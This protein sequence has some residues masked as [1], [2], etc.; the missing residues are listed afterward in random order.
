MHVFTVPASAPFLRTVIA[1]LIDGEL[2]RGFEARSNPERLAE[3]T[4]Y[5]PT[6]R[7]MRLARDVFLDVL[8]TDAAILPRL[9]AL[10]DIDEDELIFAQ[11]ASNAPATA[12][13]LPPAV[14]AFE[15]RLTLAQLVAAWAARLKPVAPHTTPLVVSGPASALAL[16]DELARLMDDMQTRGVSWEALD[17]LVP[18]TY[19]TYWQLTLDFLKIARQAWPAYLSEI[20]RIEPFAR[21]DRLI[22][23]EAER[24]KTQHRGPVVAA[25]STGSMPSTATFLTAIARLPNGAVVLPGLDTDLDEASWQSIGGIADATGGYSAHPAQG[26]P[27]YALHMLL[28]QFGI[29]RSQ[30]RALASP[31]EHGRELLLSEVMRPADSTAQWQARLAA[32]EVASRIDRALDR[33]AVIEAANPEM[34][35]LAIAIAMR[36]ADHDG[37]TTALVTPDRALARR[38]L[39]ALERWKL[40]CN[41]SGGDPLT[42]TPAGLFARLIA[43]AIA[44]QLAPADLLALLKHPLL[45]LGRTSDALKACVDDLELLLLRGTRPLAGIAGLR[46]SLDLVCGEIAKLRRGEPSLL[47]RSELR[48]QVSDAR[49]D[50]VR[51]LIDDLAGALAPMASLDH[52]KSHDIAV[53]AHAHRETAAL[54][55]RDAQDVARVF[56]GPDGA[57]LLAAFDEASATGAHGRLSAR[58]DEYP[59]VLQTA[60]SS[61]IVRR[62]ELPFARLHIYGQL[63]ARLTQCDRVI[64]GGLTETV[65]P[66]DP[67]NDPWLSRPMRYQINLDLP[68]RRIGLSAHDFVQL[69]G[70]PEVILTHAA[71]VGGAPAVASRFLHR[72]EAVA[73]ATRWAA[74]RARGDVYLRHAEDLDRP[75]TPPKPI[76]QPA[77]KPPRDARP[78]ALSVTEIEDWLRDP[79]TIY[80]RHILKLSPLDPVDMPLS[81]ADRGSAI[82]NAL[83]EFTQAF[84]DA[85]PDDA[86]RLLREIGERHFAPLME[87]PEA[88]A[89]WWPRYLRIAAWFADWETTR[90]DNLATIAAESYGSIVL[91]ADGRSF[92]LTARADRIETLRDGRFAI[93]DYKTGAPPTGKQVRLGLSPQLTLTAAILR[94]GGFTDIAAGASVAELLYVRLSGNNPAGEVPPLKLSHTRRAEDAIPPDHAADEARQ[95]LQ[96]LI[97]AFENDEQPYH[98]LVL[99]M[100]SRRYGTYDDLARIKE[101]SS[102]R[103]DEP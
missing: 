20:D 40:V 42:D 24:L 80:A 68:E 96:A 3:A 98:P 32:P 75:R 87:R 5:L 39:A 83:G 54:L 59:D 84:P 62:A 72:L 13:Q 88:R 18:D 58:L 35:A 50:A 81:A 64:L 6:R 44:E 9:V 22:L 14:D 30:V 38:V 79:Y 74:L 86:G 82:H 17:T 46:S 100:W 10:G 91:P 94:D 102:G 63:E 101:W 90:R 45:T 97:L 8:Q 56:T 15:R 70:A 78:T 99:S 61:R 27:Q 31:A 77:P 12:L 103:E 71:K 29:A 26:H 47:H 93:L 36:E 73:G 7:A 37:L 85:L 34:E 25:G 4:I 49:I 43:V 92:R 2:V 89:L 53:L 33:V 55:S 11:A 76:A 19:D 52:R 95:K 69:M 41:D 67:R 16:A 66:P 28:K 21:R 1:A 48:A 65:W 23:A 51:R 60:F 57:A